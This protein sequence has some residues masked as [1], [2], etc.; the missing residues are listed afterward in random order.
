MSF[1]DFTLAA[2]IIAL[3][4]AYLFFRRRQ[5]DPNLMKLGKWQAD[6]PRCATPLPAIRKP[7][8]LYEALWG[9]GTCPNCGA[10]LDK[11]GNE[12]T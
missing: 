2:V 1:S 5:P 8:S 6:C 7:A 9:G 10:K 11:F 12:R 4:V 3:L